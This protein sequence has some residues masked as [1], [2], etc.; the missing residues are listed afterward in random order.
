MVGIYRLDYSRVENFEWPIEC[1]SELARQIESSNFVGVD[2]DLPDLNLFC[3]QR[4][5]VFLGDISQ[6]Y[7]DLFDNL[8]LTQNA[9]WNLFLKIPLWTASA[10]GFSSEFEVVHFKGKPFL[11][12]Q[13]NVYDPKLIITKKYVSNSSVSEKVYFSSS[14]SSILEVVEVE[15]EEFSPPNKEPLQT[16][17]NSYLLL[18]RS[19]NYIY[20]P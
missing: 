2:L 6:I 11:K 13:A 15:A 3:S 10:S 4:G 16:F 8:N 1:V 18:V 12:K 20:Y 7:E 17:T 9:P 19:P 14:K 5:L